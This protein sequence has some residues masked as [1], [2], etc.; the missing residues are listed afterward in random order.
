MW[1]VHC[2]YIKTLTHIYDWYLQIELI[3][4]LS[5][6]DAFYFSCL[7]LLDRISSTIWNRSIKSRD[8][9]LVHDLRGKAFSLSPS[10]MM[11]SVGFAKMPFVKLRKF[12][13]KLRRSLSYLNVAVVVLNHARGICQMLFLHGMTIFFFPPF[14]WCGYYRDLCILKHSWVPRTNPTWSY[15]I[16]LLIF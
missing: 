2:Y 3:F 5:T 13:F 4:F 16:N 10:N 14:Y 12:H 7:T 1:I 9:C 11:L 15:F 6:V 8:P